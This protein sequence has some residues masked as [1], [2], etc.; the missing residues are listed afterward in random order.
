MDE[1]IKDYKDEC[2]TLRKQTE[3]NDKRIRELLS[4]PVVSEF[5]ELYSI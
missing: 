4:N 1:V 2:I 3:E 5:F